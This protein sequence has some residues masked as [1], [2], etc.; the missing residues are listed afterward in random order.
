MKYNTNV[1]IDY[2]SEIFE[3]NAHI[4]G[5]KMLGK[6]E[7]EIIT[8]S[9]VFGA[10]I[11]KELIFFKGRELYTDAFFNIGKPVLNR[12]SISEKSVVLRFTKGTYLTGKL[13]SNC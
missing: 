13:H 9:F 12:V 5:V 11:I 6:N 2:L 4:I 1:F 7:A 8:T 10:N 3:N